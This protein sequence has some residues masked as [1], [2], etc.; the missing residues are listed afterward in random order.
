MRGGTVSMWGEFFRDSSGRV[1]SFEG[2]HHDGWGSLRLLSIQDNGVNWD[3]IIIP[4][5]ILSQEWQEWPEDELDERNKLKDEFDAFW[6]NWD[7]F[8]PT[9]PYTVYEPITSIRP[10]SSLRNEMIKVIEQRLFGD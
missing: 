6:Q 10:L 2:G 4:P 5:W 8:N 1:F 7:F 9:S 3:D